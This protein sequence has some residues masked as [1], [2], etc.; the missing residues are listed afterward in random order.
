LGTG[1]NKQF[2]PRVARINGKKCLKYITVE[3]AT[4]KGHLDQKSQG[5]QST[6]EKI[7]KKNANKSEIKIE[8]D[9][10]QQEPNNAKTNEVYIALEDIDGKIYSDQTG[11]FPRTSNREMK[12]VMIFIFMMQTTL[13]VFQ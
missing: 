3:N 8:S 9:T 1:N 7:E 6:K 5:L 2:F 11:K 4:V 12:Y 10:L 13:W